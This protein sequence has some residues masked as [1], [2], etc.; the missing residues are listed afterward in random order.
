MTI[1]TAKQPVLDL[2]HKK[3]GVHGLHSQEPPVSFQV[4]QKSSPPVDGK[5]TFIVQL[6]EANGIRAVAQTIAQRCNN[7]P[8][9]L[10]ARLV[11]GLD[12]ESQEKFGLGSEPAIDLSAQDLAWLRHAAESPEPIWSP[13]GRELAFSLI[14]GDGMA[15][16][17]LP[18]SPED[19][20]YLTE[21]LVLEIRLAARF[22]NRSLAWKETSEALA[23]LERAETAQRALYDISE[24]A[25]A[26]LDMGT[27]LE[28]V[29]KIVGRLMYAENFYIVL[30]DKE[31]DNIQFLYFAD[32]KD[33]RPGDEHMRM[34]MEDLRNGITW[35]LI[36]GGKPLM[37]TT[38]QMRTQVK[39]DFA[40]IGED[41]GDVLGVPLI[42]EGE[43]RGAMVV[44]SYD[45]EQSFT[46][47]DKE[48]LQFVAS[49]ILTSLDRLQHKQELERKV[50]ERTQEL[51][52]EVHERKRAEKLQSALYRIAQLASEDINESEFYERLHEIIGG[53]INA[54]NFY[55][56]LLSEDRKHLEFPYFVDQKE[57]A[58]H[59]RPLGRGISEYVLRSQRPLMGAW[60]ELHE[61][62][63]RGEVDLGMAGPAAVCWLGVPLFV[64][65][66]AIGVVAV[67]GY[68][69]NVVYRET[70]QE[71][72]TFVASQVATSLT[73]RKAFEHLEH[74]VLERTSE[75]RHEIVER[76]RA[77]EQLRHQVMHDSLTGL[78]NRS[79]LRSRLD[80]A[81]SMAK[82]DPQYRFALLY[83]DVDRFKVINDSLGHLAGDAV[84]VEVSQRLLD[85]VRTPDTPARL[86]GDEFAVL[87]ENIKDARSAAV[88][89]QSIIDT[90]ALP[91]SIGATTM[92]PSVSVGIAIADG[93]YHNADEVLRDADTA[94]YRAKQMGR[95]RYEVFHDAPA[96][97]AMDVL[98]LEIEI[99]SGLLNDQFEPYLQ[100]IVDLGRHRV[101]GYES[102]VRWRHPTRGVLAPGDFMRVAEEAG[103]MESIDWRVFELGCQMLNTLDDKNTFLTVNVSP[104]HFE[105]DQFYDKIMGVLEKSQFFPP[106]L[107]AEITEGSLLSDPAQVRSTLQKLREVGIAAALDDFGTG[108]SSLSYLHCYPLGMIKIDKSFVATLGPE[109]EAGSKTVVAAI[110]AM[111]HA[112][113]MKVIAEGIETEEQMETLTQM[114]CDMG[115]GYFL[116]RP[117]PISHWQII[118]VENAQSNAA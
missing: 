77:Q 49:H 110:I 96:R 9:C 3:K 92:E 57:D 22:F 83:L 62:E 82:R 107:V 80:H 1:S 18:R 27:M 100:P 113:G 90:L 95:K 89:A 75:L 13:D 10:N 102:L 72:L 29:H 86:S 68:D 15:F 112:M 61:L 109:N 26:H 97:Q 19:V 76:E 74:M 101:V 12:P 63:K 53:L 41:S 66:R 116:G 45:D 47:E 11:W 48:L 6:L 99:K 73:R 16:S 56:A 94:L 52:A 105:N 50:V 64:G 25:A 117:Q 104:K 115:Q 85:V 114:G 17:I 43:V 39:G 98:S 108:Y 5:T 87:L 8:Q 79:N 42:D 4:M 32:S 33:P 65:D 31:Q 34:P 59:M 28:G 36:K 54:K 40:V 106:R 7:Y 38:D 24:L 91:L 69:K 20:A 78:P 103:I 44:Q 70:D 2:H 67:Q 93:R 51:Q 55:V 84:L 46:E 30:Y 21:T 35:H 60:P 118:D 58:K 14:P 37:G 23:K 111:A 81:L 88:V 71:L